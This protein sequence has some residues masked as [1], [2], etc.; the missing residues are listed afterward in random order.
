MAKV[1]DV[2]RR[3]GRARATRG[4]AGRD[5]AREP[6]GLE[7]LGA[8]HEERLG[9]PGKAL[10]LYSEWAEL[11]TRRAAAL[12]RC[13]ARPRRRATRWSPPRRR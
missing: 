3:A 6:A 11:G 7:R 13:C 8:L 4:R 5:G 10:A 2:T 12:A 9:D 1:V